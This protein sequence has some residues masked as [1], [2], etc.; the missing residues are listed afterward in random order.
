MKCS[1]QGPQSSSRVLRPRL[2]KTVATLLT[3]G[4]NVLSG[5]RRCEGK[6]T[7][8][9][10]ITDASTIITNVPSVF[11]NK[12]PCAALQD[13]LSSLPL[14]TSNCRSTNIVYLCGCIACGM[15]YVG[16]TGGSLNRRCSRH[17]M[18]L[19]DLKKYKKKRGFDKNWSE[20][21]RHFVER[22]HQNSFWV[23]PLEV[24]LPEVP[25]CQRKEREEYWVKKLQPALNIKLKQQPSSK[26]RP[27]GSL[28]S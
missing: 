23:A 14:P 16:E 1:E 4:P 25:E 19:V 24:F 22:Q 18:Q 21:R 20:V 26:S 27:K 7:L 28:A 11:W 10:D 13:T 17:R 6:C 12:L 8:C 15:Y 9:K 5:F 3:A 2:V